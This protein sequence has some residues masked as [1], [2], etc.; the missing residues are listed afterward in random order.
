M[1]P[2][3][4]LKDFHCRI[5]RFIIEERPSGGRAARRH[6]EDPIDVTR[7][8]NVGVVTG[9]D[10]LAFRPLVT[11]CRHQV[12]KYALR[13][14]GIL[15]LIANNRECAGRK[16]DFLYRKCPQPFRETLEAIFRRG[17]SGQ[18]QSVFWPDHGDA[19]KV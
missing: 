16:G 3:H 8:N 12:V 18:A 14:H 9:Q 17:A 2:G 5:S 11:D 1:R 6:H 19:R 7:D 10:E 15:R 4:T 13:R